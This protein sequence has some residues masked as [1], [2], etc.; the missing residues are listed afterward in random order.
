MSLSL[1]KVTKIKTNLFILFFIIT[2]TGIKILAASTGSITGKVIA[3]DL[4]TP[5]PGAN[6]ILKGTSLGAATDKD[7]NFIISNVPS[8]KYVVRV[9]YIGYES[10]SL[11]V[12]VKEN[13]IIKLNFSLSPQSIE[14]EE[15]TVTA[16]AIGQMQAINKQLSDNKIINVVSAARIQELPDA[17]AAESVGRLPG[18]SV[19]RNGGE[20]NKIVVRGL[21]PKYNQIKINGVAMS[22][23]EPGNRSSDLSMI[24]S[25]M[26]EG[27]EVSKT[28]TPD[29]DANVIGG[30]VNF[31]L[32]EARLSENGYGNY[33]FMM[34]GGYNNLPNAKNKFNNYKYLFGFENRYFDKKLG[35]FVQFNIE[36]KNLTSNELGAE[37]DHL[38]NSTTDYITTAL[39]L[40]D[41]PRDR[42]RYNGAIVFDYK[43]ATG[44]LKFTNFLSSG[45]TQIQKRGESFKISDNQH[46]YTLTGSEKKLNVISNSL[47]WNQIFYGFN[48]DLSLSH[49]YSEA[50]IPNEWTATFVQTSAGLAEFNNKANINPV[51][52]PKAATNDLSKTFL[53]NFVNSNS[54]GKERNYSASLDFKYELRLSTEVS[55]LLKWG[56]DYTYRKKYYN[57]EQYDGQG[58]DLASASFVDNLIINH[59][60]LPSTLSTS[61]PVTYFLD[62]DYDYGKFLGGEYALGAP[63]NFGMLSGLSGL[64][65]N[66]TQNILDNGG[67]IAYGPN[68]F[69]STTND[70]SGNEN[71]SAF[72]LM[73]TIDIGRT[74]TVIPGIRYQNLTTNYKGAR[75]I[76]SPLNYYSYNHYDTTVTQSHAYWLPGITIRYK[77]FS[78]F[79]VRFS[80][81]NTLAYPDYN[82]I[83]PRI[84]VATKSI[85]WNNYE[86]KPSRSTNLDVYF[87]FYNNTIGLLTVGGFLKRINDLIYPW[88]FYVSGADALEY[89]PPS[90]IGST[91]PRGTYRVDTY[92][93]NSYEIK[94]WG[95]EVDW[96]THFWYLPGLLSG[97]VFNINY[98]HIYSEAQYPITIAKSTGRVITYI[99]SSFTDK[100]LY[101]P[102]NIVNLSLGYDYKDFSIRLSM[103]YQAEIFTYPNFWP[104]LRSGTSPYTRWDL[105]FKQKLPWF[106][107]QIYGDL[108]NINGVKDVSVIK[109]GGVP[110]SEQDY[111]MTAD[112][113]IRWNL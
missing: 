24:S 59:F 3:K 70:Y 44:K 80:Y 104:Q 22:S 97:L 73:T 75:G 101:Q 25:N 85:A 87:S 95:F 91:N 21:A 109:K 36:R 20:G 13:E 32:K 48:V 46:F 8:G 82:A 74:L 66:N 29:M 92:I 7:G 77:P 19:L 18:V 26:L 17:N 27:I 28:V 1:K 102:D 100:L 110:R 4:N 15:V 90:L 60:G 23:T 76:E 69:L 12:E 39:N 49:S 67:A 86:L 33:N 58:L 79:D 14:G 103:L 96:Q 37:Y 5:L 89:F 51:E 63:L 55:M 11:S 34:Q 81:T 31:E 88:S 71:Q 83:I 94:D 113:G 35:V 30:V 42:R 78:W 99:D 108:N 54:F 111:G 16:Q 65:R 40:Y 45:N 105:S 57:Y 2:L 72:Y 41:I 106:G 98:T 93:N 56:A 62:P 10:Q 112:L 84:D 47:S 53:H 43:Y 64:L 50:K 38:G 107:I 68:N 9:S 52:I 61:I 6:V